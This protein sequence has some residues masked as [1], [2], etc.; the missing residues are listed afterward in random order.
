MIY[1]YKLFLN[2]N[3]VNREQQKQI[4]YKYKYIENILRWCFE[5]NCSS[6]MIWKLIIFFAEIAVTR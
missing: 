5:K 2:M 4:M 3:F 1:E 6:D